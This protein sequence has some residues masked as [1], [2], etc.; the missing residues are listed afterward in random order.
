M[1]QPLSENLAYN[2]LGG[3]NINSKILFDEVPAGIDPLSPE[4]KLIIGTGPLTGTLGPGSGRFTVTA[5]SPLTGIHGDANAGGDFAPEIKYAGYDHIVI[6]GRSDRPAYLWIDDDKVEI[7]DASHLWGKTVFETD[8]IIR[9]EDIGDREIKTLII[10]PAGENL[11]RFAIPIANLYRAPGRCGMGAVMGSKNLKAVAV[12]GSKSIRVAKPEEYLRYV[13]EL[14]HK[15][16]N[17]PVYPPWSTLGTTLLATLKHQRGEMALRNFQGDYWT[18][19]KAEQIRGETFVE[20]YAVKSKACYGCPIHCG[21]GY[22]V[23]EGPYAGTYASGLEWGTIGTSGPNYDNPRLDSICKVHELASEYGMDTVSAGNII[24]FAT[25]LYE[26]GII[27]QKD[28]GGIVLKWGDHKLLVELMQKIAY[29]EGFGDLLAEGLRLMVQKLGKETEK[30][31]YHVKWLDDITDARS[32]L[33]RALNFAVSTRGADHTRGLP[34]FALWEDSSFKKMFENQYWEKKFMSPEA[35]DVHA[36]H[37]IRVHTVIFSENVC[38]AAD[39]LETCKFNTEWV[40]QEDIN[41]KA[42]S[43]LA[44]LVTGQE[45]NVDRLVEACRRGWMVE[46]AFSIREGLTAEHDMPSDRF[47]EPVPSGPQKGSKLDR[48]KFR[49]L[50]KIYYE[51]RGLDTE[52]GIPTRE[53]LEALGLNE[54]ANELERVLGRL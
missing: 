22:V 32:D 9:M 51:E 3:R 13:E 38:S 44:S 46:R 2:F 4:N 29:R 43:K 18:D 10:G 16:Y 41:L 5:K 34:S 52:T 47:F 19:E 37:P 14:F 11:V 1:K 25:E 12:R 28:T 33:G 42:L 20:R 49:E 48:E 45:I 31:A 7:R 8:R 23:N 36:Y 27:D 21:H 24:C 30:Y 6:S 53:S 39:A 26:R 17:C 54:I 35:S 15:I 40:G 50:L